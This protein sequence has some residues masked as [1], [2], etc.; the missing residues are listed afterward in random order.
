MQ[1]NLIDAPTSL[2]PIRKEYKKQCRIFKFDKL[3][4]TPFYPGAISKPLA[5]LY[6]PALQSLCLQLS[7]CT[8][9]NCITWRSLRD[10]SPPYSNSRMDAMQ[11][12][13]FW[14]IIKKCID[15]YTLKG[16]RNIILSTLSN[17]SIWGAEHTIDA[18]DI[19]YMCDTD[20]DR[21]TR[22]MTDQMSS[23]ELLLLAILGFPDL[24]SGYIVN[25]T[26]VECE[27]SKSM[28]LA[29]GRGGATSNSRIIFTRFSYPLLSTKWKTAFSPISFASYG[30]HCRWIKF[31]DSRL[32][33]KCGTDNDFPN[34][35]PDLL[36][37]AKT[38]TNA[39][40][41]A[42]RDEYE[43]AYKWLTANFKHAGLQ[44]S[45]WACGQGIRSKSVE[46][47]H[48]I[49]RVSIIVL[50]YYFLYV[51]EYSKW[52]AGDSVEKDDFRNAN[53]D[54]DYVPHTTPFIE[55]HIR[56]CCGIP[57]SYN[58]ESPTKSTI[59]ADAAW[60]RSLWDHLEDV[61]CCERCNFRPWKGSRVESYFL[62][63]FIDLM[64]MLIPLEILDHG[65]YEKYW[66]KYL[67]PRKAQRAHTTFTFETATI[68]N[69]YAQHFYLLYM[70]L[71]GSNRLTRY[72]HGVVFCTAAGNEIAFA[73]RSTYRALY[74]SDV[75]ER[76]NSLTKTILHT[77]SSKLGGRWQHCK[78][79]LVEKTIG[80]IMNWTSWDRY[81]FRETSP[82]MNLEY[83][84]R[85]FLRLNQFKTDI[86]NLNAAN[87]M[88]KRI[89]NPNRANSSRLSFQLPCRLSNEYQKLDLF[90]DINP[91][92]QYINF[93]DP[94]DAVIDETTERLRANL[95]QRLAGLETEDFAFDRHNPIHEEELKEENAWDSFDGN[96]DFEFDQSKLIRRFHQL[97]TFAFAQD[98]VASVSIDEEC[99]SPIHQGNHFECKWIDTDDRSCHIRW[100]PLS[101][102]QIR[103]SDFN[104][105]ADFIRLTTVVHSI[106][107]T[108]E[109]TEKI[110][111]RLTWDYVNL[112]RITSHHSECCRAIWMKMA[113]PPS[114]ECKSM[115]KWN[116]CSPI[117]NFFG[118]FLHNGKL[119]L[120]LDP[121]FYDSDS[122]DNLILHWK[123][124]ST[125]HQI[126][127]YEYQQWTSLLSMDEVERA[128]S[129][130][131]VSQCPLLRIH[132]DLCDAIDDLMT[133]Y[134]NGGTRRCLSCNR[135]FSVFESHSMCLNEAEEV[136]NVSKH[137]F[138]RLL[139]KE[140]TFDKQAS[141]FFVKDPMK[142][143]HSTPAR[144]VIQEDAEFWGA[145]ILNTYMLF[146]QQIK[147]RKRR[148]LFN[149]FNDEDYLNL[150]CHVRLLFPMLNKAF[151]VTMTRFGRKPKGVRTKRDAIKKL[152]TSVSN[153][154]II[155]FSIQNRI[156]SVQIARD[157][158]MSERRQ[159]W[160]ESTFNFRFRHHFR[161]KDVCSNRFFIHLLI[162]FQKEISHPDKIWT[163]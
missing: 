58:K 48:C 34:V 47:L 156:R 19:H 134:R 75:V 1:H 114:I 138:G 52:I 91:S 10:E 145:V 151:V 5:G 23:Q 4:G 128:R 129:A 136:D 63:M 153:M 95:S 18:A 46:P 119:G 101:R 38:K 77:A 66:N 159:I 56:E 121:L 84:L 54:D 105:G 116:E 69:I 15:G 154:F 158:T 25:V 90:A 57:F 81:R 72:I 78:I 42:H 80:Q 108:T 135:D 12:Y 41:N 132:D 61:V 123:Y 126:D 139:L 3:H 16:G 161:L 82:R 103:A 79:E 102:I 100:K 99:Q 53:H 6:S 73:L 55:K 36:P 92:A 140:P 163:F 67:K 88:R 37:F 31:R 87:R 96:D 89:L 148:Q 147:R 49:I 45:D 7:T 20:E 32:A 143:F 22:S 122:I 157:M 64:E 110:M 21:Y 97:I 62:V 70:H 149:C 127:C 86:H 71:I 59:N 76:M 120:F 51:I 144:L 83:R 106:S 2:E 141:V 94:D 85:K 29:V 130:F 26:S 11:V 9:R 104:F 150:N 109:Q 13:P 93:A 60:R 28:Q 117:P 33:A 74:G 14:I 44:V 65:L 17:I 68:W 30:A 112:V 98:N 162:A 131:Q 115:T 137:V 35:K 133:T 40:I 152:I 50:K 142:S 155:P 125:E 111:F 39:H 107:P 160:N 124:F 118:E 146:V 27:D 43:R 24:E 113:A 8:I